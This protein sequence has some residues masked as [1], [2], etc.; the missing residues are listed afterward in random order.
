MAEPE[1]LDEIMRDE[2]LRKPPGS[3]RWLLLGTGVGTTA[4]FYAGAWGLR[5]AWPSQADR[6]DLKIP[7]AGPFMDLAHTGCP[8]SDTDCSTFQLVVRTILVSLDAIGQA[9][10]I[11][12]MLQSAVMNTASV[13][14]P[15]STPSATLR[16]PTRL[17][18]IVPVPWFDGNNGGGIGIT[19]RF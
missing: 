18:S 7:V 1:T 9:G 14:A 8:A 19:G 2:P 12:L 16:R 15:R 6:S 17:P 5:E 13:E 10:G 3:A 11:A 4:L